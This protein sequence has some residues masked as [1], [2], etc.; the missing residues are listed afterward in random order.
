MVGNINNPEAKRALVF[1]ISYPGLTASF[2]S[3]SSQYVRLNEMIIAN[4]SVRSL[5]SFFDSSLKNLIKSHYEGTDLSI[6][7]A[8][9]V[10][11]VDSG[12]QS[13]KLN[14]MVIFELFGED[15]TDSLVERFQTYSKAL[16]HSIVAPDLLSQIDFDL[17]ENIN[18]DIHDEMHIIEECATQFLAR[19]GGRDINGKFSIAF[20]QNGQ[21]VSFSRFEIKKPNINPGQPIDISGYGEFDG[22]LLSDLTLWL[23]PIFNGKVGNRQRLIV[24][25]AIVLDTILKGDVS[26]KYIYYTGSIRPDARDKMMPFITA[27]EIVDEVPVPAGDLFAI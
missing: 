25:S 15:I 8:P 10:P 22:L 6:D 13:E 4:G 5:I 26:Q 20:N 21:E 1:S 7:Y 9:E 24:S 19:N 23:R 11:C 27:I 17:P 14:S 2:Q 12:Y 16:M 3:G 18:S